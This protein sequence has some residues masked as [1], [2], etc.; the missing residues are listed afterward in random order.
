VS[1][2]A[3]GTQSVV[4]ERGEVSEAVVWNYER[5]DLPGLSVQ[6]SARV[7]V[8][9]AAD[10]PL[11][12][13][14]EL[15]FTVSGL[16]E[17]LALVLQ[18]ATD[19]ENEGYVLHD[20]GGLGLEQRPTGSMDQLLPM[21]SVAIIRGPEQE[22]VLLSA[23]TCTVRSSPHGALEVVLYQRR[24]DEHSV[25][26]GAGF[27]ASLQLVL[28]PAHST[29]RLQLS[30]ALVHPP[31]LLYGQAQSRQQ[32]CEHYEDSIDPLGWNAAYATAQW[33][34]VDIS[35]VTQLLDPQIDLSS[36]Q[37]R[38]GA[39]DQMVIRVTNMAEDLDN[40][41]FTN[42]TWLFSTGF[43]LRSWVEEALTVASND[44]PEPDARYAD[45]WMAGQTV[46]TFV[47]T[48]ENA[49]PMHFAPRF[50]D[51][52]QSQARD[53]AAKFRV[54]KQILDADD[55]PGWDPPDDVTIRDAANPSATQSAGFAQHE[56]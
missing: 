45:C 21:N 34:E 16:P 26:A 31:T 28:G 40:F 18:L 53:R 22:L 25:E 42:L 41:V 55:H 49:Q 30:R 50:Y 44:P 38:D 10:N 14:L 6:Q 37:V 46:K 27:K 9:A 47:T 11:S 29:T 56:L 39:L 20:E 52:M 35:K 15:E 36:V 5:S 17:H 3:D 13:L 48:F 19:I 8:A 7:F 43:K 24:G 32:W 54:L 1:Q 51:N 12:Q 23:H 4:T 33:E 2:L